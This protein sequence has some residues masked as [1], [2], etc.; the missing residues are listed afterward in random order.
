VE[1]ASVAER[2]P[3]DAVLHV[4]NPV[5]RRLLQSPIGRG[6]PGLGVLEFTG[7]RTG[8][9][10]R[11]VAGWHEVDGQEFVVTPAPW[12][13]NFAG[14][15]PLAV[16]HRGRT[17]TGRGELV[18]DPAAVAEAVQRLLGQGTSARALGMAV[19]SG[20]RFTVADVVAT[21]KALVRFT[22]DVP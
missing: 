14:G 22:P 19:A 11:V 4:V 9:R 5:L 2:R 8:R 1:N 17:R 16:T 18:R 7:R 3:P 13:A 12:R 15:A 6:L 20:H 21:R 10:Y